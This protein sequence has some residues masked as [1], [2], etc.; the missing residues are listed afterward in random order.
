MEPIMIL[1]S[2]LNITCFD[3]NP[4]DYNMVIAGASN[5][6]VLLWDLKGKLLADDNEKKKRKKKLHNDKCTFRIP[7]ISPY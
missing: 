6:Q 5:G 7:T 2:P 1:L 4:I 3:F